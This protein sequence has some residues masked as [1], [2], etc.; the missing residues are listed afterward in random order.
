MNQNWPL[1]YRHDAGFDFAAF[2]DIDET[3]AIYRGHDREASVE[4]SIARDW[5]ASGDAG[6]DCGANVGLFAAAM[7]DAVG[8]MGRVLA[9]EASPQ[10]YDRLVRVLSALQ[11]AQAMPLNICVSDT[12]GTV[13]FGHNESSPVS[14]SIVASDWDGPSHTVEAATLRSI[15]LRL[16]G[17][18]PALLKLDI[19]GSEPSALK[20]AE[21]L[22]T[23]VDPPLLIVEVYPAG[24]RRQGYLPSDILD[25]LP[26]GR[27]ELWHVNFSWPNTRSDIPPYVPLP[28]PD[29]YSYE[30]PLHS[31]L[32]AIPLF[33]C[34]AERRERIGHHLK[35]S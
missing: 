14:S 6:I 27:Y 7:A 17:V 9:I 12:D 35:V 5:L 13:L 29:P 23:S 3:L 16:K 21:E 34:F 2:R 4:L 10:T 18:E 15:L 1:V 31:N 19:E 26:L 30:W 24:L 25:Q 33:G 32:I 8:A 20:G 28:L 22:L 11:L